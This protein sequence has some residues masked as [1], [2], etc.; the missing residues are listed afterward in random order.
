MKAQKLGLV[1]GMNMAVACLVLQGCKANRHGR[2]LPPPEVTTID[3]P[4]D[5]PV[6]QPTQQPVVTEIETDA[7]TP[8]VAGAVPQNE[9]MPTSPKTRTVGKLPPP[10]KPVVS[11]APA[12]PSNAPAVA[13]NTPAT[14]S[15]APA[16]SAVPAA[17]TIH[18]VKKGELLSGI[19]KKYNV[20]ISAIVA[21]N[22]GLNPDRIRIGQKLTIPGSVSAPKSDVM[23][24]SAPASAGVAPAASNITAPVKVKPAFK[25]YTGSTKEYVVKGGD[26]LGKI[27]LA[28]GISIRALKELNGLTKDNVRVGQKLKV[29][30]EKVVKETKDAK[31]AKD[32]KPAKDVKP[33]AK[34]AKD[35]KATSDVKDAKDA[36]PASEATETPAAAPAPAPAADAATPAPTVTEAPK[37]AAPAA[38]AADAAPAAEPAA[39]DPEPAGA[40]YTVKEG[41]DIVSI[42][43]AWGISP[44]QLMNA[45]D[46][47]DNEPLKPGTVLKLPPNARQTVQ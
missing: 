22:P 30:A 15:N 40:T 23:L 43:I 13:S 29:P 1:L 20:K 12:T 18:T 41:D 5:Q 10:A 42:S 31:V 24:A 28:S 47:K 34:D 16:V 45:N 7:P 36:K 35:A 38:P 4:V 14:P 26:S 6:D 25:P 9:T 37:D 39:P 27:A 3:Q 44:S 46:L 17:T 33:A 21:S 32:A 11:N 19:S 8:S 2:D